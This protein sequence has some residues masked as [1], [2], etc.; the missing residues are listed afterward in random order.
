ME[1]T[2]F[3]IALHYI[4]LLGISF[5]IRG[6]ILL[7]FSLPNVIYIFS[8]LHYFDPYFFDNTTQLG[9]YFRMYFEYITVFKYILYQ[10]HFWNLHYFDILYPSQF[11]QFLKKHTLKYNSLR[12]LYFVNVFTLDNSISSFTKQ[13]GSF[14]QCL[15]W[16]VIRQRDS[17]S[18]TLWAFFFFGK[19]YPKKVKYIF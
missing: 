11:W 6:C 12:S 10:L 15:A 13:K 5:S 9:T 4:T 16:K 3:L 8:T 19:P 7:H 17:M 14:Q 1:G 18:R 2:A